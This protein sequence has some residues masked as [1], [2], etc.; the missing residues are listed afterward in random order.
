MNG[1]D[2]I[3]SVIAASRTSHW[4]L[5]RTLL[6]SA[7]YSQG[8]GAR[9]LHVKLTGST[10]DLGLIEIASVVLQRDHS[11]DRK[12]NQSIEV[13]PEIASLG[14]V[15]RF[16][17]LEV[18]DWV[19]PRTAMRVHGSLHDLRVF[20][21]ARGLKVG[22]G[23]LAAE[24][25]LIEPE[26]APVQ[27]SYPVTVLPAMWRPLKGS[28]QPQG[29]HYVRALNDPARI[30]GLA[31][32]RRAP[33]AAVSAVRCTLETWRSLAAPGGVFIV[34]AATEPVEGSFFSPA[35]LAEPFQLDLTKKQQAKWDRVMANLHS[36]QGLRID[37][38]LGIG[39]AG[40]PADPNGL[41]REP[42]Y[43]SRLQLRTR[44]CRRTRRDLAMPHCRCPP[45]ERGRAHSSRWCRHWQAN[46]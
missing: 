18:P 46:G 42:V 5:S 23:E 29:V 33:D 34:A 7:F 44:E 28:D 36:V 15:L 45:I 6:P 10:L 22:D 8:G 16:P 24:A 40:V 26:S 39:R 4:V 2:K 19:E 27:T 38:D 12:L 17:K 37:S 11:T 41:R 21:Y 35:D 30:N 14:V 25:H 31:V 43:I 3:R 9:G 13:A 1:R 20:V 32:L